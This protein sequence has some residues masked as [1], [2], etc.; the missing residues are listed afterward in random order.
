[1]GNETRMINDYRGISKTKKPIV[2]FEQYRHE[3]ALRMGIFVVNAGNLG[4]FYWN[5]K[6]RKTEQCSVHQNTQRNG[7][8]AFVWKTFNRN[9]NVLLKSNQGYACKF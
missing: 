1:M 7:V 9:Y 5:D 6:A 3:G 2:I 8:V 4:T